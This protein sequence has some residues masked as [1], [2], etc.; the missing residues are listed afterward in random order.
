VLPTAEALAPI[1]V[2]QQRMLLVLATILL[3]LLSGGAIWWMLRHELA[4]MLATLKTLVHLS[5]TNQPPQPLRIAKQDEIGELIGGFN[6]LLQTLGK[7]EEALEQEKVKLEETLG[8]IKRLEGLIS[9]CMNCK[10]IR[11]GSN[12][13]QQL[14][15][16]IIEHSD[17][18][19]SHGLC[20]EC[21]DREMNKLD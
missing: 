15:K 7:R 10:K 21:L 1:R 9:I 3:T 5:D 18:A 8:R 16:Y 19:F 12:E 14:E 20:P 2:M 11:S 6:R 13:W 17:A 4:P